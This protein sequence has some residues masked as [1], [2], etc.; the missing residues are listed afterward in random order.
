LKEK[1]DILKKY[2]GYDSFR[3]GQ[4][5]LIDSILRK[6]D[7]LGV[8]PTGAGKS[9]CFQ[10][11]ALLLEGI[12]IVISPLISLMKDQ[13]NT[14]VQ[15]GVKTA[16]INSSLTLHQTN[17]VINN[18]RNGVYKLIYIAP[19]RLLSE[20]FLDFVRMANI[21]MVTIDE[22]HCISQWGQDFRPSYVKIADFIESL[23]YR[24]I[25]SAFTATATP[26]VK[27]DI[28]ALL[29][30]K[31]PQVLVAGFDRKNLSFKVQKPKKKFE[32]LLAF[33]EERKGKSGIIYCSTRK[34]V[35]DVCE[36]L[37]SKGYKAAAYHAGL[38][39]RERHV[40]QDDFLYDNVQIMVATNAFGMGIDKSNVSF[41]VHYNMPKNIES[42]YQEA[43]RGGRDG[44]AADCVL[45]YNA[46]DVHTQMW[47]ID[48][49]TDMEYNDQ[50]TE[51]M[52]KERDR[53]RLKEMT[54]YCTTNECLRAYILKYFGENPPNHCGNCSNCNSEF[55]E[56]DVTT[57]AQKILF[58]V[59]RTK[60]TFGT[61]LIIDILRGSKNKKILS[62]GLDKHSTY[63]ISKKSNKELN[64]I[65][66]YL[67]ENDFLIKTNDKYPILKLG[68][69]ADEVFYRR[70]KLDMKKLKYSVEDS[71]NTIDTKPRKVDSKLLEMLKALRLEIANEQKVPAFV[72]FSDSTLIDMCIKMPANKTGF[73]D[74]LGVGEVKLE[75]YGK[76]FLNIIGE[77]AKDNVDYNIEEEKQLDLKSI[78]ITDEPVFI[79][80]IA[81][82]I[83]FITMQNSGKKITGQKINN[84]LLSK[85]YLE[86]YKDENGRNYKLP[87][88][89]GKELDIISKE[90]NIRGINSFVNTYGKKAQELIVEQIDDLLCFC[91]S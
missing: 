31:S 82:R 50:E 19:E 33:L 61:G 39:D 58:C 15:A 78:E 21:S 62:F 91:D 86:I 32:A 59:L 48:N 87:T 49:A 69:R 85:G 13:V 89:K 90:R 38:S 70:S 5:Y 34:N 35:D 45:F 64:D 63:N 16:F 66:N 29:K 20:N 28:I 55:E 56:Y 68:S 57:E 74:V 83:N 24:P 8:M 67:V 37:N 17:T 26:K 51:E 42:Y 76:L 11:P 7:T 47:L 52:L 14:L 40:N 23:P 9:I 6:E 53:R 60:E 18:A 81:D 36:K 79:S 77:F 84:W 3:D 54:L 12:T 71:K 65:I 44:E 43:G 27:D 75:R 22:A 10:L 4:E 1:Y 73:L 72:I 80:V 41:V 46:Q 2:F 30:L 88:E 25:V